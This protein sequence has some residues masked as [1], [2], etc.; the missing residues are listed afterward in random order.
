MMSDARLNLVVQFLPIDK[1]SGALKN[2]V[3]LGRSGDQALKGLRREARDLGT[4]LKAAQAATAAGVGNITRLIEEE[5]RLERQIA[6]TNQQIER[7]KRLNT[8]DGKV[9]RMQARGAEL[10]GAGTQNMLAGAG[11]LTP[12][13]AAGAE[14][15]R[16]SSGMVD[17]QQKAEL[18]NQETAQMARNILNM[19]N[20][21][22]QLPED[23]RAAVDVLAGFG[24]DPR[25][26][27]A[28][29]GP[30]GRLGTAFKVELADGAAAA[31]ANL[32]NLKVPIADTTRALDIMAA[33]GKA[34]AFEIKDMARYFPGMTAQMQALGQSGLGAVSDLTAA[35]QIARRG[36]GTSEEA[37]TNVQNLLA[38]INSPAVIRAFQKNFGVDLPAALR[39]AYAKGKTP[40][41]ALAEI[42]RRATGGDLSKLG[43]VIEDQQAQSALRT[44]ILNMD[45]YRKMR[46]QIARG[47]G[48]VDAA[49]RQRELQDASVAWAGFKGQLQALAITLGTT[50]L[51]VATRFFG[52]LNTGIGA[53]NRWAQANPRAAQSLIS[54]AA[55]LAVARVGFGALQ[56]AFGSIL[57]PAATAWGWF[58]K[59][60]E[61]GG[62]AGVLAKIAPIFGAIRTAALFMAQGV[63][64]A[65]LMMLANP[66]VAAIVL[67]VVAVGAAAYLIWKH[68]D[69]IK[70]A[71]ARGREMLGQVWQWVKDK[72]IRFP[73]LFGPLGLV[74]K[75][76]IQHWDDIK[77]KFWKAMDW[78]KND[79]PTWIRDK[80]EKFGP[81]F[82]PLGIMASQ[83]TKHWDD[84]K[85]A[86]EEKSKWLE[87]AMKKAKKTV[88]D[89]PI[90]F[91]AMFGA[92]FGPLGIMASEG[93]RHWGTISKVFKQGQKGV[94]WAMNRLG[95]DASGF[96]VLFNPLGVAAGFVSDNMGRIEQVFTFI[97]GAIGAKWNELGARFNAGVAYLKGLLAPVAG[98]MASIGSQM[99]AGLLGA[100]EPGAL[101]RKLLQI[102]QNG[103]AAFKN[104]FGIKS[105]SRL[106]MAMGGHLTGGLAMGID[107]GGQGALRAMGKL[108]TGVAGAGAIALAQPALAAPTALSLGRLS[109]TAMPAI[110]RQQDAALPGAGRT[111]VAAPVPLPRPAAIVPAQ[112]RRQ[113]D[114]QARQGDRY[115][116]H[117]HQQPGEDAQA[118][119]DRVMRLID[120]R[121][122]R[123]AL[124][125]FTDD[126]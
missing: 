95:I 91:G 98:W 108:A 34:G 12:F 8:I 74:A 56:F 119:A 97:T 76:V 120:T 21:A 11:M 73:L 5:R 15:M 39:Q 32:N 110:A 101:A 69:K 115:E 29:V 59:F 104:F 36:A 30:I 62:I 117:I 122:R 16:F 22:H 94:S 9:G 46:E 99:M 81:L 64:R 45:D 54:L 126:F 100:L 106:F 67:I 70:I 53:V 77:A 90:T 48:T 63:M 111:P 23:M 71:F 82:G 103:I 10:Q 57:G 109:E 60:K 47:G 86:W 105:P 114:A 35:L 124:S 66:M 38:K 84:A 25:Q 65:G 52:Y 41:E 89:N 43:F 24:L 87:P 1:L 58:M 19:A 17:I 51:P 28:M 3:G 112:P 31:Y 68:W 113:R 78:L 2:I 79:A 27:V 75:Y 118:L 42:T 125:S 116:I 72:I 102:A 6:E 7:Q 14:A 88:E 20:A 50:L 26:A 37:A 107:R 40:M 96:E 44:L 80:V 55:G 83:I 123:R 33:G 49:F 61:I 121:K 93:A 85:K 13:I 18:T 4:Q 92:M